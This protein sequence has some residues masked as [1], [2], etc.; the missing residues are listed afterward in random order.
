MNVCPLNPF[1][2]SLDHAQGCVCIF[3]IEGIRV[4]F[5][6]DPLKIIFV[7]FVFGITDCRKEFGVTPH[8]SHVLRW[9]SPFSL[10]QTGCFSIGSG[11]NIFSTRIS[12]SHPSPKS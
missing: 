5:A 4:K 10:R 12:C 8:S 11:G 9:T 7:L 2:D 3:K 1:P 6:A